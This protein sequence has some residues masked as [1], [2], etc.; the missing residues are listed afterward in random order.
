[1]DF[2]TR[3]PKPTKQNDG[4]MVV[5]EKLSKSTHFIPVKSTCKEIDVSSIFMKEIFRLH[6]IPKEIVYDKDTNFT[7]IFWKYLF[8]GFETKLLFSTTYHPQ[9]DGKIERV[10][11][12]LED[13]LRMHVIHQPNKWQEYLPLV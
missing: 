6:G 3:L 11:Q 10:S 4:I 12:V 1:M 9:T 2:I 8:V 7:S 5:V 13:M